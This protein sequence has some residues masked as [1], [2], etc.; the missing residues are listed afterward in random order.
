MKQRGAALHKI[1]QPQ[2]Q[3]IRCVPP[4]GFFEQPAFFR[5][6]AIPILLEP[7]RLGRER[8]CILPARDVCSSALLSTQSTQVESAF[9]EL[10]VAQWIA[11]SIEPNALG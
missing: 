5:A 9:L 2:Q 11:N 3:R 10:S 7:I 8:H 1:R 4:R 6:L